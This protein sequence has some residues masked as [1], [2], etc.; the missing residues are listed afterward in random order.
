VIDT[1]VGYTGNARKAH[2]RL[3]QCGN[4]RA[5]GY[6]GHAVPGR[7]YAL[8]DPVIEIDQQAKAML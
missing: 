7:L 3:W 6:V 8:A 5:I 4:Q 1:V 2:S